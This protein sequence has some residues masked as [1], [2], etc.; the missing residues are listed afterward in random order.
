MSSSLSVYLKLYVL[1]KVRKNHRCIF[2]PQDKY[3]NKLLIKKLHYNIERE[4]VKQK[5][6]DFPS[7]QK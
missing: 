2:S 3:D 5:I 1:E 4:I 6:C 7:K